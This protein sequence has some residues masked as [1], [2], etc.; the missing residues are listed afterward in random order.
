MLEELRVRDLALIEDVWLEFGPGMTALTGETGAGKTALVEA[1]QL[2]VGE[3][4]DATLVRAGSSEAVVEGR[5]LVGGE[6]ILARRRLSAQGRSR[7]SL[8]D[9]MVTVGA[10]EEALGPLVD[11][12][13]QHEHQALLSP[14]KHA[15][16]LDRFAGAEDVR[17]A[18]A[19]AHVALGS[20]TADRDALAGDLADRERRLGE[21]RARRGEID[22]VSP[23]AGEDEELER[24]L[25]ALRHADRLMEA[26]G[27]ARERLRGEPGAEE[28]VVEALAALSRVEGL[29]PALDALGSRLSALADE[30]ADVARSVCEYSETLTHDPADL[31]AAEAR[32]DA[33]YRLKKAYGPTLADVLAT[34]ESTCEAIASLE[35]GEDGLQ[36]ADARVEA[37]RET[38]RAAGDELTRRRRAAAPG[39]VEELA[40]A[41]ADLGMPSAAFEVVIADAP[42]ESWIREGP[43][44]VEFLFSSSAGETP[45]PLARVAS[46]GEV[47]RVMLALKGVLGRADEV[48]VL[49]FDEV[50]AGIGGVT[51]HAV[52]RRLA[53]LARTRQVLVVTHLAQVAAYADRHLVVTKEE[54]DGRSVTD[55]RPV[56]GADR[57]AEIARMLSGGASESLLAHASEL[58]AEAGR[59]AGG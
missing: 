42:M 29:D 39:F 34:R 21:L 51:A 13:G 10:L 20:A 17:D 59:T 40:S 11:L 48:P 54:R 36:R 41:A 57:E 44:S 3:R 55:V 9:G 16:Y 56:E 46:G 50:D 33:L 8:G 23:R 19:A 52:G 26:V 43:G 31:D 35:Q 5:F 1:L 4:A 14:S 37:A 2:L 18:Y 32:S 58:L 38:L 47:S 6:E 24:R 27:A 45:R 22:A 30:L 25:P 28:W 49:V 53:E 7:C 15:G 12:H